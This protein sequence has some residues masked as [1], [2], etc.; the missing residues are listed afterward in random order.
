MRVSPQRVFRLEADRAEGLLDHSPRLVRGARQAELAHRRRQHMVDF[1]ERVVDAEWILKDRLDAAS[2]LAPLVT[3]QARQVFALIQ[4]ATRR[5]QLE[6]EYQ[7]RHGGL[8][9]A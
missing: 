8:A 1:V 6:P 2:E 7:T 9:A 5:R 3:R 4:H